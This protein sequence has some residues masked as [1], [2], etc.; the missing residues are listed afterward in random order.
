M[1]RSSVAIESAHAWLPIDTTN[2]SKT[3]L[4]SF[5][6]EFPFALH[7]LAV[8]NLFQER[9]DLFLRRGRDELPL[10]RVSAA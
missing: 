6:F 9:L 7:S 3:V 10:V 1:V 2:A 4:S 5:N 8:S